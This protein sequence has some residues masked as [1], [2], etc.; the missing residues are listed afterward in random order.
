MQKLM[1]WVMAVALICST[2]VFTAC[3]NDDNAVDPAENLA[4]CSAPAGRI[5]TMD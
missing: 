2:T 3:T 4:T 5:K 1:Q